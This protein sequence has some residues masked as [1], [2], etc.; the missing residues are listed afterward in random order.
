MHAVSSK[1]SAVYPTGLE[2]KAGSTKKPPKDAQ[3]SSPLVEI[4]K[5]KA[6]T[7]YSKKKDYYDTLT[8]LAKHLSKY[9]K[10]YKLP[11]AY[12]LYAMLTTHKKNIHDLKQFWEKN[13][14]ILAQIQH[15]KDSFLTDL[16][17]LN[18]KVTELSSNYQQ[19]VCHKTYA[20]FCSCRTTLQAYHRLCSDSQWLY[21][22]HADVESTL[23]DRLKTH[24]PIFQK[25]LAASGMSAIPETLGFILQKDA[26]FKEL[27]AK[28]MA[29]IAQYDDEYLTKKYETI[30]RLWLKK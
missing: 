9:R 19:Q 7:V 3:F 5:T 6:N 15:Q 18:Q 24:L 11:A 17:L 1:S 27:H 13:A 30:N 10:R 20:L 29:F 22:R 23:V 26:E 2:E 4:Y 21:E 28:E 16:A 8:Q 25:V 14:S 12:S